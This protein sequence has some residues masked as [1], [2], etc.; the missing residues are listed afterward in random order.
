VIS[1]ASHLM[2]FQIKEM[3]EAFE[4]GDV[5]RAEEIQAFLSPLYKALFLVSNP[6][7][8]KYALNYLGYKVGAPRLPLTPPDAQTAACIKS[9]LKGYRGHLSIPVER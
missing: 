2:G 3:I 6:I 9:V 7:P 8:I 1:V 4:K 5:G